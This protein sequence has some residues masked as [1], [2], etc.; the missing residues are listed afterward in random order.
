MRDPLIRANFAKS[1]S[2]DFPHSY[3]QRIAERYQLLA[4][5]EL[6]WGPRDAVMPIPKRSAKVWATREL[7]GKKYFEVLLD[8]GTSARIDF[9]EGATTQES[10]VALSRAFGQ[11]LG[12]CSIIAMNELALFD[13]GDRLSDEQKRELL[14]NLGNPLSSANAQPWYR[15]PGVATCAEK[16][17]QAAPG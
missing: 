11:R 3:Y 6:G 8:D 1:A 4:D 17:A 13:E 2:S 14:K 10:F 7:S 9:L 15:T 12:S 5:G 16:S